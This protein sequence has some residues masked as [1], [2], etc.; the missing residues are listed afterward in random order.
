MAGRIASSWQEFKELT[1]SDP[2]E[3]PL[4]RSMEDWQQ[5]L[6]R[7]IDI[8]HP[9]SSLSQ[10]EIDEFTRNLVFRNGGLAGAQYSVLKDRLPPDQFRAVFAEFGI[11]ESLLEMEDPSADHVN[12]SCSSRGTCAPRGGHICTSNC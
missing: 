11:G 6:Q 8:V 4:I 7:P 3:V 9:L 5:Y 10:E 2:T 1:D 12:Y